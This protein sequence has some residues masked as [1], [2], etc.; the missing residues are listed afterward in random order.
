MLLV[1]DFNTA[2]NTAGEVV[3]CQAVLSPPHYRYM[4]ASG[5]IALRRRPF[6]TNVNVIGVQAEE[7]RRII[8]RH[9]KTLSGKLKWF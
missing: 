4:L 6:R 5:I 9:Q 3:K 2:A 7:Q 1:I 8:E